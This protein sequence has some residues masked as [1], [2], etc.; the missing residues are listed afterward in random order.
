MRSDIRKEFL[1]DR[2]QLLVVS[3]DYKVLSS[4]NTIFDINEGS[5][6]TDFHPFFFTVTTL[7]DEEEISRHFFCVQIDHLGKTR[8]VDIRT[9]NLK[10]Y[11]TSSKGTVFERIPGSG[12]KLLDK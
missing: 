2:H 4:D 6:I 12:W 3:E 5:D 11:A 7:F 10:L 1:E 8:F 9:K